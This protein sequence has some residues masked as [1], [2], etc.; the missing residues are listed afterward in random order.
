MNATY[1]KA[2]G[3]VPPN[4]KRLA[5]AIS[6]PPCER[7][8]PLYPL[9]YGIADQ[10]L[11]EKV[12]PTLGTENYPTLLA[13]KAYGLRVLRPGTYVYLCYFENARMWTLHYQVTEDVRFARIW[14]SHADDNDATPGRLARPDTTGAKPY[15]LAPETSTAE[16]VHVLVSDTLL[17]HRTLWDLETNKDGLRDT[18][19]TPCKPAGGAPQRHAFDAALLGNA[20]RELVP[21]AVY[22]SPT[23]FDWSEIHFSDGAP[24]HGNILGEMYIALRPRMDIKPLAVAL[25]DPIGVASELHYLITDAVANKT[26]YA[27]QNAHKLQSATL[28]GNYFQATK[29]QA[30]N[31][32][33]LTHALARQR[34]LVNYAGAMSFPDIYANT[35][36]TFDRTIGA[37]VRDSVAWV[38]LIDPSQLLGKALRCFDVGVIHN[39]RDYEQAV[40]QCIGGLIHGKDGI[41]VMSDLVMTPVDKSPYW[42]ALANGNEILLARLKSTA[43]DI[44]KNVFS[45]M[46]KY[47]EEHMAT[48]ATNA[49]IGLL[50]ALPEAGRADVLVRRLRHVMEIRA[51]AT[52]VVYDISRADLQRAAYEFQGYQTL[53]EEGLRGWKMPSPK[54]SQV[55]LDARVLI[56]DWVKVGETTY[57]EIDRGSSDASALPAA[58]AIQMETSAFIRMLNRLRGPG[59]Y[60]FTGLAGYL[61][62]VGMSSAM[63]EW[64]T[65]KDRFPA[66]ASALGAGSAL[67]A[68]SI[69][70]S[71]SIVSLNAAIRGNAAIADNA[72]IF[73]AKRGTAMFGAGA[74]GLFASAEAYRSI[75]SFSNSNP[76]QGALLLGS[77][78]ANGLLAATWAGGMAAAATISGGNGAVAV[79]GLTPWGWAVVAAVAFVAGIAFSVG[80]DITKHGPVEIWL[81]HSAWGVHGR[82]YTNREELDAAHS[83]YFRPR[84]TAVWNQ[85]SG[86]SV[87]ILS[88]SCQ[89]PG[90]NDM[91]G[92]KF[93]TKL[94]PTLRGNKLSAVEGPIV[95]AAG[96]SPIDYSREYLVTPLGSTGKECGWLI[97]MH[98]HTDV[99]IEYL[100]FP[101]PDQMPHLAL[102]QPGAPEPLVFTS[103]GWFSDPIDISKL[104]PVGA[105][106]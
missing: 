98:E 3:P 102:W 82:H 86:Y 75:K 46:D 73:A 68:A 58:R 76:E 37:A 104:E 69:E 16:V 59:G 103:G 74:A 27:G 13:G 2:L 101:D 94:S 23:H 106:K 33:D 38:H 11:D 100:Y 95:H 8:V 64:N 20:T 17:S 54:V 22:G 67:I 34:N 62:L 87:G 24:S 15:L 72:R 99:S 70:I 30:A 18:L 57:R 92:D 43:G 63:K 36:K 53:G 14:W 6:P 52:I 71:A 97:Q 88:I 35:I 61:A 55:D 78:V 31:S 49:L 48:P 39:A 29:K 28:I 56:F 81:K 51:N 105:P 41:Q 66:R 85:A 91:P 12:F 4:E 7:G 65:G 90:I 79:L 26:R 83:L 32:P 80:A 1:K 96:S 50:Q 21:P 44:A 40:F 45:V 10:P 60:L 77:A 25:Q 9:R 47:I 5:K 89:L 84:L 42:L 19:A 93:Q